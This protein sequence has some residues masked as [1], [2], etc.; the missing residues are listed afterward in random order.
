MLL[1]KLLVPFER[2]RIDR[3]RDFAELV[4]GEFGSEENYKR[5]RNEHISALLDSVATRQ[6][7]YN[8]TK[9]KF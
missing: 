2:S 6:A 3:E 5:F 9:N 8:V 1:T 4:R 7:R